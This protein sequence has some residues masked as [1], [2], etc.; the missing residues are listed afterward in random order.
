MPARAGSSTTAAAKPDLGN[1][2]RRV[3]PVLFEYDSRDVA[4]YSL[5][6]GA[7][8]LDLPLVYDG[9]EGGLRVLPTFCF[10]A[11]HSLSPHFTDLV[12]DYRK[13]EAGEH[14]RLERPLTVPG[15][16]QV[17]AEI[18]DIFDKGSMA[19]MKTRIEGRD[20]EGESVFELLTTSALLGSGG[21][22]GDPGPQSLPRPLPDRQ[23]D[24]TMTAQ[25]PDT[26]AL[27]YQL[28]GVDDPIHVDPDF[29]RSRGFE[30]PILHGPA[31]F[32]YTCLALVR[33]LCA[34]EPSRLTEIEA[35]FSAPVLPGDTLTID[36]WHDAGCGEILFA[37]ATQN[38]PA[39][40]RGRAVIDV[41][42][43]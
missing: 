18:L 12:S 3:G 29:A 27:L 9:V 34:G 38:A 1:I 19:L 24:V 17:S 36:A 39:L 33:E 42:S 37:A 23:P 28:N 6:V 5:S 2:G 26:Q 20:D 13:V 8:P 7:G 11:M 21:F 35:R 25:I 14:L 22:G 31:T 41:P 4:L 43:A 15:R 30:R 32:G 16:L 40:T 10:A